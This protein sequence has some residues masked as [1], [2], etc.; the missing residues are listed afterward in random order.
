M[1]GC[2]TELFTH[3]EEL[4]LPVQLARGRRTC[5][6]N[7]NVVATPRLQDYTCMSRR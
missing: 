5:H 4:V 1:P 6:E 3:T 7:T 2:L